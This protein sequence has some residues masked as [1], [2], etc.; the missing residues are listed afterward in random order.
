MIIYNIITLIGLMKLTV[1]YI[2]Y[3]Y[4]NLIYKIVLILKNAMYLQTFDLLKISQNYVSSFYKYDSIALDS[5]IFTY[6]YLSNSHS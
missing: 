3:L 2:F 5:I 6:T 4:Y 1:A